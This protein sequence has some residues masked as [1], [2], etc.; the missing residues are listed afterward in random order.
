MLQTSYTLHKKSFYYIYKE[1]L[2]P[3][4]KGLSSYH[5]ARNQQSRKNRQPRNAAIQSQWKEESNET[6]SKT[7]FYF[8]YVFS[9]NKLHQFSLKKLI[10]VPHRKKVWV[11]TFWMNSNPLSETILRYRFI[12]FASIVVPNQ[13]VISLSCE[14]K[15]KKIGPNRQ[16][17]TKS[18]VKYNHQ[19]RKITKMNF[20]WKNVNPT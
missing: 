1:I 5:D 17:R 3:K 4:K 12:I 20:K 11:L 7:N 18:L 13:L 15:T 6:N 16:S 19:K 9:Y 14:K 10:G 8:G 2:S